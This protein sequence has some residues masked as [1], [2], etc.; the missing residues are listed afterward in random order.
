MFP[1]NTTVLRGLTKDQLARAG[2]HVTSAA[3]LAPASIDAEVRL[4]FPESLTTPSF[5]INTSR[6]RR[7]SG[8]VK[9]TLERGLTEYK[10]HQQ[11]GEKVGLITTDRSRVLFL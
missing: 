1:M 10:E 8:R 5:V 9:F 2:K 6:S 4:G 11:R 7:A 3:I